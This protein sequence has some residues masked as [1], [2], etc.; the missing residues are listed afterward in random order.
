LGIS[1]IV[2]NARVMALRAGTASGFLEEDDVAEAVL[3]GIAN[4]C[5]V[6]NMSFGDV[7][8]SYLLRDV[9]EYGT[10]Q[11]VIFVAAA[12]NNGSQRINYPAGFD[13]TISVGATTRTNELAGFSNY[14]NTLNLVAPGREIYSTQRGG[15]Y[16]DNNGTSF[17]APIVSALLAGLRSHYPQLTARQITGALYA[18]CR[19][20]GF[21]GWDTFFGHGI[22]DFRRSLEIGSSGYGEISFP[23]GG[24]GFN[25]GSIAVIGS[26]FGPDLLGYQL[27]FCAGEN[28]LIWETL[29][30]VA[31]TQVLND[32]L[33]F[34]NL[35]N[36]PDS[37]Y[38]LQLKLNLSGG[39]ELVRNQLV[40]VDRSAPA[41]ENLDIIDLL[42]GPFRGFQIE[43]ATDDPTRARLLLS[44]PQG[45]PLE[46]LTSRYFQTEHFF[47]LSQERYSGQIRFRLTLENAAGL[48][49][50]V[51]EY[52]DLNFLLDFQN[53][54]VLQSVLNEVE[55]YPEFGFLMPFSTDMDGNGFPEI[56]FSAMINNEQFGPV[57]V[58]EI[59]PQ[60]FQL[61]L[62]TSFPAIPRD[63][64]ALSP[65]GGIH[66]A[67]G[68][69]SNSLLLGGNTAGNFPN[70]VSWADTTDFWVSR[71]GNYDSDSQTE[72]MALSFGR[73]GL[74]EFDSA[75]RPVRQFQFPDTSQGNNQFGVPWSERGDLD[76]DGLT[77]VFYEDLDGDFYAFERLPG[78]DDYALTS[79]LN[80]PGEGGSGLFRVGDLDGDGLPELVTAA[81]REPDVDLESNVDS[82]FWTLTVWK[83][84]ASGGYLAY[85]HQNI[86]GITIQPGIQ[87][88]LS[89]VDLDLDGRMEILF[90]PFPRAYW[91][92]L[93]NGILQP[94]FYREGIN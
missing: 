5:S 1:G 21:P 47:R 31:G 46:E 9:I 89:L 76:G 87:N 40:R 34:W 44:D 74:Y 85:A 7:A 48:I 52:P 63:A 81:R 92:I 53:P 17:S 24:S 41:L 59:T 20:L 32:T 27:R 56:A 36:L 2:P 75:G 15:T 58:R 50:S 77:E 3:Y 26:V 94:G 61:R 29:A 12:G 60:G 86:A 91:L 28:G 51:D 64:S 78:S 18:G 65:G 62:E 14:G 68:F 84:D 10:R 13:Q 80:L 88:G 90:T 55:Q 72:M 39:R 4:G 45:N 6:I 19:D 25:G 69:G 79:L 67:C 93:E 33:G 42:V 22:P 70:Q 16:G 73:W 8:V 11:G 54:V 37:L 57:Q 71:L 66:L 30:D 49:L 23:S 35:D 43:M 38:T 83:A 82:K